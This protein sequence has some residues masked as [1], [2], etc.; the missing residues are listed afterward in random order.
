MSDRTY[1]WN[2]NT[3]LPISAPHLSDE[4]V[5]REVRMLMRDQLNHE[6]VVTIARDR[7]MCLTEEK[8]SL[9]ERSRWID[10]RAIEDEG[11]SFRVLVK[12][13]SLF[14]GDFNVESIAEGVLLPEN[15]DG[16]RDAICTEWNGCHDCFRTVEVKN[17]I[18]VMF[19][20]KLAG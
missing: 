16:T 9:E 7:I 3:A 19:L 14:H 11:N 10:A 5:A 2:G 6:S 13:P 8:E 18:H 20:D 17:V 12:H 1:S 4:E 15:D